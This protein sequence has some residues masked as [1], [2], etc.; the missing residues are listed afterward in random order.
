[1]L[2]PHRHPH[3][4][5]A[6]TGFDQLGLGQLAVRGR[7]GM[8]DER[9]GVAE[10]RKVTE[11][12][13]RRHQRDASVIAALE[14]E[15]EHRPTLAAEIA[16]RERMIGVRSEEHTSLPSLMRISYAVFCLKKKKIT[17]RE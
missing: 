9:T 16:L 3:H 14:P 12:L 8:D 6:G 4:V 7:G 1:M 11:H 17:Q 13:D 10:V 15:G 5:G 2:D